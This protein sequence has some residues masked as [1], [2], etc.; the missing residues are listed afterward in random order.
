MNKDTRIPVLKGAFWC[1]KTQL[2]LEENLFSAVLE[3]GL[4]LILP[5]GSGK[6][7]NSFHK[8]KVFW[9][10]SQ[11]HRPNHVGTAWKVSFRPLVT[12]LEPKVFP[13]SVLLP[14]GTGNPTFPSVPFGVIR[15]LS[16]RVL[17]PGYDRRRRKCYIHHSLRRVFIYHLQIKSTFS[18]AS[19]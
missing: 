8:W 9:V 16:L 17:L 5:L 12:L 1:P 11:E 3:K 19:P 10:Q 14:G 18:A 6:E 13:P 15:V 2:F 4:S 7:S